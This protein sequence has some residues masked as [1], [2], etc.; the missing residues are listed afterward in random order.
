MIGGSAP[1]WRKTLSQHPAKRRTLS[2]RQTC[3]CQ[4]LQSRED[5]TRANT[6]GSPQGANK[7]RWDFDKKKHLNS[8]GSLF[9]RSVRKTLKILCWFWSTQIS[10]I[11]RSQLLSVY[12][13]VTF[14]NRVRSLS[15]S[16]RISIWN[17]SIK[18]TKTLW[19]LGTQTWEIYL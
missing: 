5:F 3:C 17:S 2:R 19:I 10:F 18:W 13:Y 4:S 15:L 16:P 8:L 14:T 6:E 7:A 11:Y 1:W 12:F 9:F